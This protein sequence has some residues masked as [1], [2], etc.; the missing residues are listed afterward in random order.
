MSKAKKRQRRAQNELGRVKAKLAQAEE[1]VR[2]AKSYPDLD[3]FIASL[4]PF[5]PSRLLGIFRCSPEEYL[6]ADTVL[7]RNGYP[8]YRMLECEIDGEDT[9]SGDG[10]GRAWTAAVK[11]ED[12]SDEAF[13]IFVGIVNRPSS[14]DSISAV[15]GRWME[16]VSVVHELGHAYDMDNGIT[17]HLGRPFDI[18]DAEV[19][20]HDFACRLLRELGLTMGLTTYLS[21]VI[22]SMLNDSNDSVASAAR[23]FLASEEYRR[24][25]SEIPGHMHEQFGILKAP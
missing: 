18:E 21:S 25:L 3:Q 2:L 9:P 20:A 17:F 6:A 24:C 15:S 14:D 23:R 22:C 7:A 19:V 16:I 8:G 4:Q 5:H 12:Q 13:K 1:I 11:Q 10:K